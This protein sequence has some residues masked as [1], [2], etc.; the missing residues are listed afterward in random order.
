MI[1]AW[2]HS[3]ARLVILLSLLLLAASAGAVGQTSQPVESG[4]FRLHKFEQP[5]GEETYAIARD[6]DSLVIKSTFEFTDR[7]SKVPLRAELRTGRD[8]T[9]ERFNIKGQVS[10]FSTIDTSIEI[11]AGSATIREDKETRG[12]LFDLTQTPGGS[13][14]FPGWRRDCG[15]PG[16]GQDQNR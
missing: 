8:L 9:P 12:A 16:Q 13:F 11:K 15:N 14:D 7:G 2:I 5:I 3:R 10:R 1:F 4:R 6:G